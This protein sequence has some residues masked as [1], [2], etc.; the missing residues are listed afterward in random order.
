ML[1]NHQHVFFPWLLLKQD[2]QTP[3]GVHI[4]RETFFGEARWLHIIQRLNNTCHPR[5]GAT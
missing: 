5:S 4:V 2:E 3:G 1:F